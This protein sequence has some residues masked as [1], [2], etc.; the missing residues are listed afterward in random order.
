[1]I[2]TSLRMPE[3]LLT[4]MGEYANKKGISLNALMLTILDEF[5][6]KNKYYFL[7]NGE[8]PSLGRLQKWAERKT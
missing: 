3:Q 5:K 1:M 2:Q 6:R 7:E 4:F 8:L